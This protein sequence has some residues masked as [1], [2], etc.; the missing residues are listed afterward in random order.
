MPRI[1]AGMR[2]SNAEG[3]IATRLA[4]EAIEAFVAQ[5]AMR[6]L[7]IPSSFDGK[8]GAFVTLNLH[9]SGELRGCI[10]YPEPLF[11]LLKALVKSAEGAA[12]D[13]RF[14][15]LALEELDG[16]VVE[17]SLLTPPQAIEVRKAKDLPRQVQ[18]GV[19]GLIVAQGPY[20]GLLLPQV[21]VEYGWTPEEF[22]SETCVKAGLLPD[23][24]LDAST[25]LKKFQSEIFAEVEPRG[26]I[27][28]RDLGGEHA[29]P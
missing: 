11:P 18:V 14:P 20:R 2:Y 26:G 3:E 16:I 15:P 5:R 1:Q 19:D 4:R 29:R 22:L 9:P 21:A 17:V 23:A 7:D 28:R 25:R 13:P 24:W 27:V 8:A 6:S 10:G 12:R